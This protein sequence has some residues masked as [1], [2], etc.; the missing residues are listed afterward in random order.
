MAFDAQEDAQQRG[1]GLT[2]RNSKD[3]SQHSLEFKE[4]QRNLDSE[5]ETKKFMD[6]KGEDRGSLAQQEVNF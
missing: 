6:E 1:L 5:D 4:L 2:D 3:L